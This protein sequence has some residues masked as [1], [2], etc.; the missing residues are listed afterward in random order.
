MAEIVWI[1]NF[2]RTQTIKA[3]INA[4]LQLRRSSVIGRLWRHTP[5]TFSAIS[6]EICLTSANTQSGSQW[7]SQIAVSNEF[8]ALTQSGLFSFF[9]K[10]CTSDRSQTQA[11]CSTKER[12]STR[13]KF[14]A[15]EIY[16]VLIVYCV[17]CKKFAKSGHF[18]M[19]EIV[20][21]LNFERTQTIKAMINALLQ[22][23]RSSVI[24]RLWRHTPSTFSAISAEICLTSAN[25]QSGSQWNSQIAVSNEFAALTQSGLFSFF[26]NPALRTGLKRKQGAV[27]KKGAV[28]GPSSKLW[29]YTVF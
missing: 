17:L 5:S 23:R 16:C 25:T 9:F 8:A 2:E 1:L 12:C 4:L 18:K 6:A 29:K 19:A 15:L 24:G 3:M 20:W 26:S 28:P 11:R 14:K 13:T 7:N 27:P 21:I 22:L 10:S